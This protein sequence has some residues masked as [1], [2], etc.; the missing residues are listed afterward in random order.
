MA[1]RA[2]DVKVAK[3]DLGSNRLAI[4]RKEVKKGK[5]IYLRVSFQVDPGAVIT[6]RDNRSLLFSD[7]E[8]GNRVTIDF[9]KAKEKFLIKGIILLN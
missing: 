1:Y 4:K 7:L 2:I 6:S 3:V 8:V 9:I 5:V